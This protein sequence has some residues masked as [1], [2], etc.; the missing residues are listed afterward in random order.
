MEH[1]LVYAGNYFSQQNLAALLRVAR[2]LIRKNGHATLEDINRYLDD[3]A[4]RREFKDADQ[5]RMCFDF[6]LEYSQLREALDPEENID[7][8]RAI[9]NGE[10]IYFY[11]PTLEEPLT[12]PLV[13][14]LALYTIISIAIRRKKHG[15]PLRRTRIF[16]DEFQEIISR[17][18]AALLAQ[19]RKFGISLFLANQS[20]TQLQNRDLS[21]ADQIFEGTTVKQYYTCVGDDDIKTLQSLSKD[22]IRAIENRST[23]GFLRTTLGST[24]QIVPALERDTILECS[25]VFGESFLVIKDGL[26]HRDPIRVRQTHNCKDQSE[27]PMR[28]RSDSVKPQTPTPAVPATTEERRCRHAE[29]QALIDKIAAELR[30]P[31]AAAGNGGG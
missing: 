9:E 2:T 12:A 16:I 15:R 27:K 25:A 21:L 20:T 17:A 18:A 28:R 19:S 14:G 4:N 31:G 29:L 7:I 5:V 10:L 26:G 8:D 3:P 6:L 22:K 24:D 11:C 23:S 1:G 13:G 30:L